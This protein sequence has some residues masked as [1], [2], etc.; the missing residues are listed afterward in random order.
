MDI[1]EKILVIEF[2]SQYSHL[3]VRRIRNLGV[4]S[5]LIYPEDIKSK[6]DDSVRGVILSGG[7]MSIYDPGSPKIDRHQLDSINRPILGICYGHQ[8]IAYLYGG[9]VEK[10]RY[11]EYGGVIFKIYGDHPILEGLPKVSRVWMSHRDF[12]VDI[13]E[14]FRNIGSTEYTRYAALVNEE[15]KIYTLQFHPEVSHTEYGEKILGNFIYKICG[16]RGGY[17][18]YQIIQDFIE[19]YSRYSDE[20]VLMAVSGGVDSTV[21]AFIL[22]E[23][24]GDNLHLVFIDTGFTR[25]DDRIFVA[26]FFEENGFSNIHILDR[27]ELFINNLI[28]V[29][30]PEE[31][32]RIFS[33]L[34]F[35]VLNRFTKDLE[36][37][38]GRFRFLGQGTLYPDIVESGAASKYTDRIKSHHNV[39]YSQLSKLERI[40]P[41]KYLYK[42]EVRRVAKRLGIPREVYMKHPFPGPGYLVRI[43]GEVNREKL[44]IVKEADKIVEDVLRRYGV[45]YDIW[46]AFAAILP[47]KTVGVKGDTRTYE[48]SVVVRIVESLDGMTAIHSRVPYKILDEISKRILDEVEGVNRVFYD[49]SDK[50]PSTIEYE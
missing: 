6:I 28:G 22:R 12:V 21:A 16:C 38:Y 10:G 24:F 7:P 19:S 1:K 11:G 32:R 9:R 20:N 46:Q 47:V 30:D 40:E 48:Y 29:Y 45:Y 4:Y 17:D 14:G 3:I 2:G 34:Y 50:P 13:P 33:Q 27:R 49:L 5:E 39:A 26:R 36:S 41:L 8:L 18:P 23:V 15:K 35:E 31:K 42:D 25:D 43:V 44:R 37:E